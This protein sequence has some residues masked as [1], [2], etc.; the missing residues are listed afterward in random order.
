MISI[1]DGVFQLGAFQLLRLQC[2]LELLLLLRR[3]SYN[4]RKVCW[5]CVCR[6]ERGRASG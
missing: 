1:L 5:Q 2:G 3:R 6:Q 4:K